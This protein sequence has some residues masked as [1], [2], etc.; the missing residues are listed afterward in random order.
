MS[1]VKIRGQVKDLVKGEWV[2]VFLPTETIKRGQKV[3]GTGA[4][5]LIASHYVGVGT[6]ATVKKAFL[7][8]RAEFATSSPD[9]WFSVVH[10]REGTV[11]VKYFESPGH[12][13]ALAEVNRPI[14]SFSTG[15][16]RI[17]G[18]TLGSAQ[19]FAAFIEGVEV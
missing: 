5:V 13:L 4:S 17:H 3:R 11:G 8:T 7:V 9:T 16:V 14:Y 19:D 2:D 1:V 10:S 15:T 18:I 6:P 12:Q